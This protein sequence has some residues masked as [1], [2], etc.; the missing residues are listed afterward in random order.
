MIISL[1]IRATFCAAA[2]CIAYACVTTEET[3]RTQLN[4]VSDSQMNTM[5][6]QAYR[7]LL[8]KAKI[9]RNQHVTKVVTQIG[10]KIAQASGVN[11]DWEFKVIEDS[12]TVNAFCLPG[13]KVAVYTGILPVAENN[14]ALAAVMGH[15]V[16]HAVL[17]HSAERMSQQMVLQLGMAAASLTFEDSRYR[18][19]IAGILGVG[20]LYGLSL[21]FSRFH[22]TEADRV[23]LTYMAKAGFNPEESVYLWE[24][25]GQM[26]GRSPEILSTHPDPFRRAQDLRAHMSGA[27]A[28]Y[29]SASQKSP[30]V[31]LPKI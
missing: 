9:S 24:R 6:A 14:A 17:R 5:G 13:G 18:D 21:P 31:S 1:M 16:A 27:L 28:I 2:F 12:K 11:Y 20:A 30:T 8:S 19:T 4:L 3:G 29:S 10:E 22:E 23:G 15:E 7:D 25:M 26:G